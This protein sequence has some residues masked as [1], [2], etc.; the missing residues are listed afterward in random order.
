MEAEEGEGK[1]EEG[2]EYLERKNTEEN[3]ETG[4]KYGES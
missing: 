3:K 4:Y 2:K 1:S